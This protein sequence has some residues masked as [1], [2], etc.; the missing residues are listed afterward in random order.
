VDPIEVWGQRKEEEEKENPS[1]FLGNELQCKQLLDEA[2]RDH[3]NNNL[4][5]RKLLSEVLTKP[6]H[7]SNINIMC[8]FFYIQEYHTMERGCGKYELEIWIL[9]CNILATV[10]R[11]LVL[12]TFKEN[13]KTAI[14]WKDRLLKDY[15]CAGIAAV[16][17]FCKGQCVE[18]STTSGW[19]RC[20]R[21]GFD[22]SVL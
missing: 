4:K 22:R 11:K 14:A 3:W 12:Q 6:I 17:N 13:P 20:Y 5:M 19:T 2:T 16:F 15:S 18:N 21:I 1:P 8:F 10:T 9:I 7:A